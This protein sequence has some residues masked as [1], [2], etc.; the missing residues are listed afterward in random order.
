[1]LVPTFLVAGPTLAYLRFRTRQVVTRVHGACP[2]CGVEQDFRP[3]GFWGAAPRIDCPL[4]LNQLTLVGL[5][6]RDPGGPASPV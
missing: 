3:P 2:R 5:D 4:C 6:G 1:V